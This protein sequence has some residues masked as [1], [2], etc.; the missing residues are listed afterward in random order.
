MSLLI[1]AD[2]QVERV[3]RN[4]HHNRELQ[5]CYIKFGSASSFQ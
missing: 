2:S 1:L 5:Y 4:V 3:W